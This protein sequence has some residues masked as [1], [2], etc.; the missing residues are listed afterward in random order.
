M[1]LNG[2]RRISIRKKIEKELAKPKTGA[3]ISDK[4]INSI[5]ILANENTDNTIVKIISKEL[6]VESS[7]IKLLI[8]KNKLEK[9]TES[10]NDLNENDFSLFCKIKNKIIKKIIDSEFDLLLNYDDNN[11]FLNYLTVLSKARFKVGFANSDKRLFNLMIADERNDSS[12]FNAE[13]KKY[14]KILNKIECKNL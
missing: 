1:I 10:N 2:F 12:V 6:Y 9:E 3:I 13:L 11:L 7:K 5:L 8:F 14:L 4:K